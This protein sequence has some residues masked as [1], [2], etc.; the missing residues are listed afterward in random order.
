MKGFK[1]GIRNESLLADP[2]SNFLKRAVY[3]LL[4]QPKQ[5]VLHYRAVRT[6]S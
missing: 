5:C 1:S 2:E 6:L 3:L 4:S